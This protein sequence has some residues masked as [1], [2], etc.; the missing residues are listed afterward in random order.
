M[1]SIQDSGTLLL[2]NLSLKEVVPYSNSASREEDPSD[3]DKERN[4][5]V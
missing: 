5:I 4:R 1:T 2:S 3:Y